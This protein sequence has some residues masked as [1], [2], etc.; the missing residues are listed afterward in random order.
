MKM[1]KQLLHKIIR[2]MVVAGT[3]ICV[4]IATVTNAQIFLTPAGQFLSGDISFDQMSDRITTG[5]ESDALWEKERFAELNGLFLRMAARRVVNGVTRLNNG[6]L[7]FSYEAQRIKMPVDRAAP[8]IARFSDYLST[9]GIPFV[10]VLQPEKMD[11]NHALLPLGLQNHMIENG[12]DLL[13]R[14]SE[15]GVFTVDL[16]Q[17]LVGSAEVVAR[18]FYRTDQ[19]W[20]PDGAFAAYRVI[21]NALQELDASVRPG[22]TDAALW[23]R[24]CQEDWFL[25][26]QGQR[27]GALYAGLDPMIWYTPLFDTDMRCIIH[28]NQQDFSGNYV[29]A[30]LRA[31]YLAQR[32]FGEDSPCYVYVGGDYSHVQHQNAQAPNQK[33]IL[34][35]KN[36]QMLPLQT[37][38]ATEFAEVDVIDPRYYGASGIA[39]YCAMTRP[40][41]VIMMATPENCLTSDYSDFGVDR[42]QAEKAGENWTSV[43]DGYEV[44]LSAEDNNYHFAQIPV[45]LAAGK[46]YRFA[47]DGLELTAGDTAAINAV[48]FRWNGNRIIR[49]HIY[50]ISFS[51]SGGEPWYFTV[52]EED[53][54]YALLV[55]AGINGQTAGNGLQMTGISVARMETP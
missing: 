21:M 15:A 35:I 48:L 33:R 5:Y 51:A 46:T 16:R 10:Y 28:E 13:S 50:D 2:C 43:L 39:R 14:L 42:A 53:E 4:M 1:K 44:S 41:C 27:T 25:G 52:P 22:F 19:S 11:V 3:V 26:N 36:T 9:Q 31:R 34:L 29:Q 18:H 17:E 40:D 23:E 8:K 30:N 54:E 24:H 32:E 47:F 6:M 12:T 20:N 37:F 45:S 38:L 7:T 49:N 55:Y